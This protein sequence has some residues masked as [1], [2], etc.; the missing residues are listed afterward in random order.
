LPIWGSRW[1]S[2]TSTARRPRRPLGS[3]ETATSQHS[4]WITD[5]VCLYARVHFG[6]VDLCLYCGPG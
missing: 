2:G 5:P 3:L 4:V 1:P 6:L